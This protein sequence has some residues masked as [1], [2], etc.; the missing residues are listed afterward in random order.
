MLVII[1]NIGKILNAQEDNIFGKSD[2]LT[3][4][5]VMHFLNDHV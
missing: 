3:T 4:C 5:T 1:E 2:S